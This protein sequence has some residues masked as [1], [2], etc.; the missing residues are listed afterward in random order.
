M[1]IGFAGMTHLGINTAV[2]TAEKGWNVIGYDKNELLIKNLNHNK[3]PIKEPDL[4]YFS[5]KNS[6]KL[7]YTS[8]LDDLSKCNI[9][10][11]S[12]DVPTDDN[13]KSDLKPIK[14]LIN[15]I[16]NIIN[17]DTLL[18]IL[19]QVP[20]GFCRSIKTIPENKI[21]YQVETLIFGKAIDRALNPERFIIGF[22][23]KNIKIPPL[24]EKLLLSFNCPI[25]KMSYESAELTKIAINFY[26]V[27]S[28]TTTNL[29]AEVSEKIGADWFDIMPALR[30]DKRIGQYSYITPGLGISGGNLERDL[31][32]IL[33]IGDKTKINCDVINSWKHN[34]SLRKK[35]C[36]NKLKENVLLN[37]KN[38]KIALL[39]LAYKENTHSIKN[40]PSLELLEELKDKN[41]FTHDPVVEAEAVKHGTFCDKTSKCIENAN[42]LIISTPW[43]EYK[44]INPLELKNK[45]NG[46]VIIDPFRLLNSKEL[47]K[48]GFNYHTL[49]K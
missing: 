26:L 39:G 6:N 10:Y 42:V 40:S 17:K 27:S 44:E 21:F 38:P 33:D 29:L 18:I 9:I 12:N 2:A 31:N 47:I 15:K 13:A 41:V 5:S 11:I 45:M 46:N 23:D 24:Y 49:G 14:D 19:C 4:D 30:M 34:S 3:I 1:K 20:P 16:E 37:N 8:N 48:L 36:W 7:T 35:W 43:P 32:T 28:V 25:I 22:A